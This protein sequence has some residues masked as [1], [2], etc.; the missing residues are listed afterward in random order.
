MEK[1][2]YHLLSQALPTWKESVGD[3]G[4]QH[5]GSFISCLLQPLF[6]RESLTRS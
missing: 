5:L 3:K 6:R 4:N 2:S 1:L